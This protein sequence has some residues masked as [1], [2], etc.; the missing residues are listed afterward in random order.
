MVGNFGLNTKYSAS[1]K[2]PELLFYGKF[3]DSGKSHIIEAKYENEVCLPRRGLGCSSHAI[4]MVKD[5]LPTFHEFAI[6]PLE[7]IYSSEA[8]EESTRFEINNL[9]SMVLI[10]E[11]S[12]DSIQS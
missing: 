10:N 8:I 1:D 11:S 12:D 5:K 2:K 3:D 9:N 6:S 7:D 4:P